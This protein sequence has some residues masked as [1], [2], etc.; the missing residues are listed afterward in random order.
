MPPA[1]REAA[2]A[3]AVLKDEYTAWSDALAG[4]T[5]PVVIKGMDLMRATLPKLTPLVS[6]ASAELDNLMNIV[7]GGMSTPG[8]D[9]FIARFTQFATGALA[10]GTTHLVEFTQALDTG[11]IG[12]D[13]RAFLDYAQAN[14]PLVGDTLKNLATAVTHLLVATS[15]MGVSVLSAVDALA[16]LVNAIPTG[17]LS[18]VLQLYAGLKLVTLGASAL[19]A[20]TGSA[21]VARL[22]AYFAVMRA[23]GVSATL[24]A[25]AASMSAMTKATV[26]LGVLAVA[27]I[28]ISKLAD[29]A[30]GAPP[31]IDR[32][33]TSLKKL[34]VT[35]KMSGELKATFGGFDGL[36]ES[37]KAY[38]KE[39]GKAKEASEGVF[40]FR[41]PVL[42]DI[43]GWFGDK[44]N[45]MAKGSKS[46]NALKDDFKGVDEALAQMAANG[47]TKEA[48]AGFDL[49][50]KAGKKAG[51]STK[52][53]AEIFPEYR[54]ALASLDVQQ[55]LAAAGMGVFG[56]Q[57][58]EVGRKL[59]TQKKSADGLRASIIALNDTNRSAYD[60]Q[61]AFEESIDNLTASFKKNGSTLDI[62][63]E[64]GRK[65][66][67]AMSAAAKAHDE[68]IASGLAAGESLGSMTKKS[69]KLRGSMMRLATDA[70][71][72]NK[73]KATEYVNTL[74][75]VP[76][77]IATAVKLEKDEAVAGLLAVQTEIN[78]TPSAKSV[79]VD[80]LNAAAI[81]ALE[82]VGYKTRTLPDGRTEVFAKNG[83]AIGAIG[84]VSAALRN[85]DGKTAT[86]YTRHHY[87][88]LTENR[89][90]N[91]GGG[92]RGPNAGAQAN[93]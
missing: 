7:A 26:G 42:D 20:V 40:G 93:G 75:G 84:A 2:A 81:K 54:D 71:D 3:L 48:A 30:R 25:T 59:D 86:V 76:G 62:S 41:I 31:D 72:G 87:I 68:M 9:Q 79:K 37:M 69:D 39:A 67:T 49:I 18:T 4:D 27:A 46:L 13:L 60:S 35:G 61:I 14:G 78:R 83:Q 51:W 17:F 11:E 91:S 53:I 16:K 12:G 38:Q 73:K 85:L 1:S 28:G 10:H 65:N 15:D 89:V 23:A 8:F 57:A 45:D 80:T 34:A 50:S 58:L 24:R 63:T 21:A 56:Q 44:A 29:N 55:Q 22:G 5:M 52:E 66:G 90:I 64:A 32:L 36:I 92:G 77:E 88:N 82:A 6:G 74:L 33:T 70:F 19:G 47:S 43:G